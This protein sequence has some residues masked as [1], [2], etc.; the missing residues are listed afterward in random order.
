MDALKFLADD[1]SNH[2][3]QIAEKAQSDNAPRCGITVHFGQHIAKNITEGEND[4]C[5]R[6]NQIEDVNQLDGANV[7][8]DEARHKHRGDKDEPR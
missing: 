5:R 1:K 8:G 6:E 3:K 4:Y 2:C 7:C